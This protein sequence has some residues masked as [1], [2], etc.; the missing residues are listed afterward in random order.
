MSE[1]NVELARRTYDA[2]NEAFESP[3]PL[4]A[5]RAV[6]EPVAD[7]D[8]EWKTSPNATRTDTFKGIDGVMEFFEDVFEAFDVAQQV[9]ER[10]FDLGDRVLVFVQTRITA[11]ASGISLDQS[12]AH[13]LTFEDGLFTRVDVYDDRAQALEAAGLSE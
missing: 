11:R 12:S 3:D 6:F 9:P 13:L 10:Y 8:V 7:P 1:E 4:P 5:I 2:Y